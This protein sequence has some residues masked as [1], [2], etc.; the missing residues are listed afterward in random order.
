M[1]IAEKH[2]TK[3]LSDLYPTGR[4][5]D[6]ARSGDGG[7]STLEPFT[8]GVDVAFTD[9]EGDVFTSGIALSNRDGRKLHNA[10]I[11][12]L[13]RVYQ[14]LIDLLSQN[15]PDNDLFSM[16]DSENWAR[17]FGID[18]QES[19]S[20]ENRKKAIITRR[21]YP[22]GILPRQH[23]QF[24]QN[25]LQS[26]G[27]M[28]WIHENRFYNG[29]DGFEPIL[30]SP[31]T[32]GVGYYGSMYYNGD[33]AEYSE[34]IKQYIDKDIDQELNIT[35]EGLGAYTFFIAGENI[36]DNASVPTNRIEEFRH[37][38]LKLKPAHSVALL[39]VQYDE[40]LTIDT[41]LDPDAEINPDVEFYE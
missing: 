4:A 20:I 36:E 22:N 13:K 2:I 32:Y 17:V 14:D 23:Y 10:E 33:N 12:T 15:I 3:L 11:K 19:L 5:W 30:A 25:Y 18:F 40:P 38:V 21:K 9:G 6:F 1:T 26:M 16:L 39:R 28:V 35:T 41:E 31:Q 29:V 37:E 7:S 27:F 24:M 34:I 8:D